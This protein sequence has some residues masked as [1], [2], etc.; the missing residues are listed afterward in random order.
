MLILS[1]I[2]YYRDMT[3]FIEHT[4]KFLPL[5]AF[6]IYEV[7]KNFSGYIGPMQVEINIKKW[8]HDW[9]IFKRS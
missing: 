1:H 6:A 9:E 8:S 4:F 2:W 3:I 7:Q 5:S